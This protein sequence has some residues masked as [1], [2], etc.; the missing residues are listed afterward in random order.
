MEETG[1]VM[2]R[3]IW[4]GAVIAESDTFELVEGNVYFPPDSVK[5]EFLQPSDTHTV[6]PWK[7]T[8]SYYTVVVDGR[9]NRDGAW[10]YPDPKPAAANIRD[11]V[12]FWR[13]VTVER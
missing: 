7:G 13:G 6:C 2:P 12:A 1:G 9:E 3:A 4:N 8:A 5:R 10:Y 11:H